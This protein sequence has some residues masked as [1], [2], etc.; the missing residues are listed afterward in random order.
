MSITDKERKQFGAIGEEY[1]ARHLKDKG[2]T[3]VERNYHSR[4]GEI[5][6]IACDGKY[7]VFVEVKTRHQNPM[8]PPAMAVTPAKQKKIIKTAV[9]YVIKTGNKLQPRFDVAEVIL[10]KDSNNI[11][12]FN[13]YASAFIQEGSY[14]PF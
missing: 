8:Y 9:T 10:K 5:D 1:V 7:I 6:I 11:L 3:I 2:Y 13:Y 12:N 14:A 4:Y